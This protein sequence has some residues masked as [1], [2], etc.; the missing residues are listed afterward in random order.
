MRKLLFFA[1]SSACL[2]G[3]AAPVASDL[4]VRQ[5]WPWETTVTAD[6]VL[7]NVNG[8]ADV[9]LHAYDGDRDLGEI[10]PAAISPSRRAL[11]GDRSHHLEIDVSRC[12]FADGGRLENFRLEISAEDSISDEV[13]YKIVTLSG[14]AFPVVDVTRGDIL[15]GKY[16][17]YE[18]D[19]SWIR[20]EVKARH[21][22]PILF[23]T[24]F[25]NDTAYATD[26][27]VL[28]RI[29]SGTYTVGY[30]DSASM[31]R[32]RVT[33]TQDFWIGIFEV[34]Q[35]QWQ[36]A[37]GTTVSCDSPGDCR[38]LQ[39]NVSYD[40]IRGYSGDNPAYD[41]PSGKEVRP[42]SFMGA[43]RQK[44]GL[45]F[46]LPTR[47][48]WMVAAAAGAYDVR[49]Y[50]GTTPSTSTSAD[51]AWFLGRSASNMNQTGYPLGGTSN[52][53]Q[54]RANAYGL[55]DTLGNVAELVLDWIG[56]TIA[57]D[58]TLTD[59]EGPATGN[60]RMQCGCHFGWSQTGGMT[61]FDNGSGVKP[62]YGSHQTGFR[63]AIR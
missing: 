54:Y 51:S 8:C 35:K 32:H 9:T 36:N 57:Q 42:S 23:V 62:G 46:D 7:T 28:R 17:T 19:P 49:C 20:S 14:S 13:L 26:K 15:D 25:T 11:A 61:L 27:L 24:G 33:L 18:T 56:G 60:L 29:P 37:Y 2:A 4:I 22:H 44:T 3:F 59:P 50:D 34:T 48:E 16:G 45:A 39:S 5:N 43:L 21:A 47:A 38:P 10:P 6:F 30:Q 53:G 52:V 63:A 1:L 12:D 31:P 58:T 40:M 55:Y 41:W